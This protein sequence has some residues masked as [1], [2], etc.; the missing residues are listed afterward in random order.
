MAC[1]GGKVDMVSNQTA[2]IDSIKNAQPSA[3]VL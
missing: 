2:D 3:Q 1:M